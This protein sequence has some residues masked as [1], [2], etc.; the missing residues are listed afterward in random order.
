MVRMLNWARTFACR[1][2]GHEWDITTPS[3]LV[4]DMTCKRCGHWTRIHW[5]VEENFLETHFPND[6][7]RD[8]VT[9]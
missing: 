9:S 6:D 4:T 7:G 3:S 1:T 8:T 2:W 5:E